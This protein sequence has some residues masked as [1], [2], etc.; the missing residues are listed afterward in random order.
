MNRFGAF[1]NSV[2]DL[3]VS[4]TSGTFYQSVVFQ[5]FTSAWVFIA[6]FYF[7]VCLAKL[8][9]V[10]ASCPSAWFF[11][12]YGWE[13]WE[14]WHLTEAGFAAVCSRGCWQV[15]TSLLSFWLSRTLCSKRKDGIPSYE[16]ASWKCVATHNGDVVIKTQ[17]INHPCRREVSSAVTR[18][19]DE[20]QCFCIY[21]WRDDHSSTLTDQLAM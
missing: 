7:V 19:G 3:L 9:L 11:P 5:A 16:P 10:M 13:N 14:N 15:F 6:P 17:E 20:P 12:I 2:L 8:F 18:R 1:K 4:L 21:P